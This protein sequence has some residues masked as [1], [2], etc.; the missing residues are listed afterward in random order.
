MSYVNEANSSQRFAAIAGT[1]AV[2]LLVAGGLIFGLT[3]T[4]L[5]EPKP[6][7]VPTIDFTPTSPPPEPPIED[8]VEPEAPAST[9]PVTPKTV[10]ELPTPDAPIIETTT[11]I[12]EPT[13]RVIL[14]AGPLTDAPPAPP[15][16]PVAKDPPPAFDPVAASPKNGPLGWITTEQYPSVAL[17]RGWEGHGEYL[18]T[19]GTN[20]R[21]SNCTITQSTGRR[22]LDDA[23]CKSVKRRA[24]FNPAI[25]S[26]GEKVSGTYSGKV[27]WKIPD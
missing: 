15:P 17:R 5:V 19:I 1:G 11:D 14:D 6:E 8:K 21:V 16:P 24:R 23:T 22:V 10:F 12:P 25:N 18:L 27:T 13:K 4:G 9:P 3:M 7:Y 20:G 2:Q 26:A